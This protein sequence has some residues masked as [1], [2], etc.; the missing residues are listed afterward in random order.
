MW[1]SFTSHNILDGHPCWKFRNL[2]AISADRD[3]GDCLV[4]GV[5]VPQQGSRGTPRQVSG[6]PGQ[7]TAP[8]PAQAPPSAL[9]SFPPALGSG[10]FLLKVIT[11]LGAHPSKPWIPMPWQFHAPWCTLKSLC[12]FKNLCPLIQNLGEL[13]IF[14]SCYLTTF[15]PDSYA[16]LSWLV[17]FLWGRQGFSARSWN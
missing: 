5:P 15:H 7:A 9:A 1:S 4:W 12:N 10:W 11:W 6:P 14:F 8:R 13:G 2:N 17:T 16:C 3:T